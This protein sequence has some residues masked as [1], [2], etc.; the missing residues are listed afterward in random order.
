[1]VTHNRPLGIK[2]A[3]AV[4]AVVFLARG[5]IPKDEISTG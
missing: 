5:G 3:Q 2:G 4:A 1:M